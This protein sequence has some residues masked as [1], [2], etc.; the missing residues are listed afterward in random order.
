MWGV[1][2]DWNTHTRVYKV[3]NCQRGTVHEI[4]DNE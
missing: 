2:G 3:L 1:V 4:T